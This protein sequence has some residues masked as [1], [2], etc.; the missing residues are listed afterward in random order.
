MRGDSLSEADTETAKEYYRQYYIKHK[1]EQNAKARERYRN[2]KDKVNQY[3]ELH[4]DE[5]NAHKREY[6]RRKRSE[7]QMYFLKQRVRSV[8]YKAFS[9]RGYQKISLAEEIT[10]MSCSDLCEYLTAT[11]EKTY[12]VPWNGKE[13]VHIDHIVP[14]ALA[15]SEDDVKNL[16]HYSNLRLI[17]AKDNL[18]KGSK[19]HYSIGD[20][21][22]D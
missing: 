8:I 15:S 18:L 19:L 2:N 7:D 14:L 1:E 13:K 6:E 20:N 5:R 3:K 10:G 17:K 12:G 22:N 9:R 21:A 11:Y 16:N 4:R